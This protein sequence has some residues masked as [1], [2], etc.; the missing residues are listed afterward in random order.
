MYFTADQLDRPAKYHD[1]KDLRQKPTPLC[2]LD[3]G[4]QP[5]MLK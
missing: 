3:V 2:R 1:G 5:V 4:S